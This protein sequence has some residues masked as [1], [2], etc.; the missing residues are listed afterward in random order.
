MDPKDGDESRDV[1]ASRRESSSSESSG[2]HFRAAWSRR[3]VCLAGLVWMLLAIVSAAALGPQA[4]A[5]V[6]FQQVRSVNMVSGEVNKWQEH[7]PRVAE[8]LSTA[9][10]SHQQL[11]KER[12]YG[13]GMRHSPYNHTGHSATLSPSVDATMSPTEAAP[14]T[15]H[16]SR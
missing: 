1:E 12:R 11:G 15:S 13:P 6:A 9:P 7:H 4:F 10:A 2:V 16:R 3:D 14:T 8:I 5:F